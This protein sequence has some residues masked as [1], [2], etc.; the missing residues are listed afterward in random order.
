MLAFGYTFPELMPDNHLRYLAIRFHF[1][2][3]H[4]DIHFPKSMPNNYSRYLAISFYFQPGNDIS[5]CS[6]EGNSN[7]KSSEMASRNML[8]PDIKYKNKL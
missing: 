3:G 8:F 7:V 6:K 2:P 1:P 5:F 4:L